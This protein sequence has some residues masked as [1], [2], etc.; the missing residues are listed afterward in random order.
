MQSASTALLS[1]LA[2]TQT[3][4]PHHPAQVHQAV[5]YLERSSELDSRDNAVYMVRV[6]RTD[7]SAH[8]RGILL[9]EPLEA[10]QPVSFTVDIKPVIH[11]VRAAKLLGHVKI[12]RGVQLQIMHTQLSLQRGLGYSCSA[13]QRE[14]C[15]F[16]GNHDSAT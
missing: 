10:C 6:K 4:K 16:G 11:E 12:Q 3:A 7:G 1:W 15:T 14:H 2:S 8:Q 13:M 9:R 5:E